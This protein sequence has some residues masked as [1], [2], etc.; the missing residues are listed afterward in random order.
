MAVGVDAAAAELVVLKEEQVKAESAA[1]DADTEVEMAEKRLQ[2]L[3]AAV[4]EAE[5]LHQRY[6]ENNEL[7]KEE[8]AGIRESQAQVKALA[9]GPLRLLDGGEGDKEAR[10]AAAQEVTDY[11]L[12][13]KVEKVLLSAAPVALS[14]KPSERGNFDRLTAEAVSEHINQRLAELDAKVAAF[15]PEELQMRAEVAGLWAIADCS[16][17]AVKAAQKASYNA[18]LVQEEARAA[19]ALIKERVKEQ[20]QRVEDAKAASA[21]AVVDNE[22]VAEPETKPQ[23]LEEASSAGAVVDNEAVAEPETK[24]QRLE[25]ATN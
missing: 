24:R 25:E 11:L 7:Q 17:D 18:S 22:A 23:K 1:K 19:L 16:R 5:G 3:K 14:V 8:Y 9:E 13:L 15:E 2:E 20:E 4:S 21:G 12:G 6:E 10:E